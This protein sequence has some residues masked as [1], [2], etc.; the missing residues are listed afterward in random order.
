MPKIKGLKDV[1][2]QIHDNDAL[3][4][5]DYAKALS[6]FILSAD[7]PI[8]IGIHGDWGSGKSSLM[9]L[10]EQKMKADCQGDKLYS[11]WFN[12]WQFSQ[13]HNSEQLS[14]SLLSH[15]IDEIERLTQLSLEAAKKA[16]MA[17]TVTE[18]SIKKTS[19]NI[20]DLKREISNLVAET[21]INENN[22]IIVFI[23]D[24]DRLEPE[25][26]L[27]LL[28]TLKLFL[29]LKGCVFVLA[30]DYQ[31]I[32]QGLKQ[33]FN[34][35][36]NDLKGFFEKMIQVPFNMPVSQYNAQDF[37][38][39][40]LDEHLGVTYTTE[41]D[42]SDDAALYLKLVTYSA[43][44]NPRTVKWLF[45]NLLLLKFVLE[46]KHCFFKRIIGISI[47]NTVFKFF[48][49][50]NKIGVQTLVWTSKLKFGLL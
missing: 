13:F 19:K 31:V 42:K 21:L 3:G 10:L 24:I 32:A 12:A 2:I 44:F 45:N 29:D 16:L 28:E 50:L 14:I 11:L 30:C 34:L 6:A 23:D 25:K 47:I 1:P 27:D 36:E 35:S 37:L 46:A 20:R 49:H 22:R 15:F 8:T 33:K 40:M 41:Q 48:Y 7:T 4:L 38:T 9:Y 39:T 26:A 17:G 43:G 5:S 18:E